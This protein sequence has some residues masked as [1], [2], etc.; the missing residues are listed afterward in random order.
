MQQVSQPLSPMTAS[1][2]LSFVELYL[3]AAGPG[4][5]RQLGHTNRLYRP[6]GGSHGRGLANGTF[7]GHKELQLP[8]EPEDAAQFTKA[9]DII[10]HLLYLLEKVECTPSQEHLK[11]QTIYHLLKCAPRGKNGFTPLHMAVV[12]DTTNV[13]HKWRQI[14]LPA[15]GQSAAQLRADSESRS[16]DNN[17]P[18]HMAAQNNCLAIMNPLIQAGA[19]PDATTTPSGRWPMSCWRTSCWPGAPRSPSTS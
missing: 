16:F 7:P 17:T 15:R 8:K 10:L 5:Q 12:K 14:H 1:S 3:R 11:H 18:L 19:H 9:L 2:F 13:Y 4:G 6:R